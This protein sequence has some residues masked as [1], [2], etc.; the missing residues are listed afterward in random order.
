M[1]IYGSKGSVIWD[2]ERPDELWI[3][4]RNEPNR[5]IIKDPSLLSVGA[6]SYADLPGGHSE[7]YDDTFKQLMR[8]FYRTVEDRNAPVEYPTF[9]DGLRQLMVL[10]KVLESSRQRKWLEVPPVSAAVGA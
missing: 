6:K 1:E 7:G 4:N 8:R 5:Y 2:Q 3:G 9:M 10:E